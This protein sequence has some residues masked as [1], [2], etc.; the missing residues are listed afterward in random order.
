V[1]RSCILFTLILSLSAPINGAPRGDRRPEVIECE[2]SLAVGIKFL[3]VIT[4]PVKGLYQSIPAQGIF[5][6][7]NFSFVTSRERMKA[8]NLGWDFVMVTRVYRENNREKDYENSGSIERWFLN[9]LTVMNFSDARLKYVS[10]SGKEVPNFIDDPRTIPLV[11]GRGIPTQAY[12]TLMQMKMAGVP[13]GGL[14]KASTANIS[15]LTTSLE[16]LQDP[17]IQIWM[18]K[19]PSYILPDILIANGILKTSTGRY[20]STVLTQSGHHIDKIEVTDTGMG[21]VFDFPTS[22]AQERDK[23]VRLLRMGLSN[24]DLLP[25]GFKLHFTLSPIPK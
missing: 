2:K 16:L 15:N 1:T 5:K 8:D 18:K 13:Y 19:H 14:K 6:Y 17:T 7:Q 4:H 9:D 25:I 11:I 3:Y 12:I 23:Y 21:G 20:M 24:L 22:D 10:S